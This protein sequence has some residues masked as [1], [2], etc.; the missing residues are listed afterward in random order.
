MLRVVVVNLTL[1][2]LPSLVYGAYIYLTRRNAPLDKALDDAPIFWLFGIGVILMLATLIYY[3]Q[4]SGG[5]RPG[6]TYVPPAYKDGKIV[7]GHVE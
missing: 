1:L 2:L 7:P 4:F 5:G 3:I 6:Q